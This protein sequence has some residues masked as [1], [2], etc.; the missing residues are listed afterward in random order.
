MKANGRR[1]GKVNG[2]GKDRVE[3]EYKNIKAG[4]DG[5]KRSRLIIGEGE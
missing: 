2:S 3:G 4:T 1:T 5:Y